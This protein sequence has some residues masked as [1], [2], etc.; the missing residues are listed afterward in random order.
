MA[1]VLDQDVLIQRR[2][3]IGDD[4]SRWDV[5]NQRAAPSQE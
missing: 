2:T 1:P 3:L 4:L 5:E